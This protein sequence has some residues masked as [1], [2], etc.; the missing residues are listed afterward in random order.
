MERPQTYPFSTVNMIYY[1]HKKYLAHYRN[2][3][4]DWKKRTLLFQMELW[5][6]KGCIITI[7]NQ[8]QSSL[9]EKFMHCSISYRKKYIYIYLNRNTNEVENPPKKNLCSKNIKHSHKILLSFFFFSTIII[10]INHFTHFG[11]IQT[12]PKNFFFF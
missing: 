3:H 6:F 1:S 5:I 8:K 10:K 9:Y 7:G 2:K 4:I 12:R 11:L